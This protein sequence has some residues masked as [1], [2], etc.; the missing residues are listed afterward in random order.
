MKTID[1]NC[2]MGESFGAYNLGNDEQILKYISSANVA[3]GFHA[4]DPAVMDRTVKLAIKY[5]VSI[6]AHPGLPDLVG[7]GR[8]KMDVSPEEVYQMVVYQTGALKAFVQVHGGQ[9]RHVKP[10]GALY[11]MAAANQ[12]LAEAIAEAIA[13]LDSSLI[14]YG[15][16]GS[17]LVKAGDRKGLLT[18]REAF[19][20]RTYQHDGT[21][22]PRTSP[23]AMIPSGQEAIHQA[24]KL[25][26]ENRVQA[27][28]GDIIE[29]QVDTICL[30][31]D[32]EHAITFAEKIHHTFL[33]EGVRIKAIK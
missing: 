5:G 13:H 12:E 1:L 4:G 15:L 32:R 8:R 25:V 31:G 33:K 10:H 9:L 23:N 3:C 17:E 30:H 20:D 2:D 29:V 24:M 6:G 28:N 22:T 26:M 11:H 7:F 27:V 21:L 14:L 18:A 16:S 19:A